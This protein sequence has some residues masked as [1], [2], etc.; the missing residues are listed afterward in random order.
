LYSESGLKQI[1]VPESCHLPW[2]G[3]SGEARNVLAKSA[4]IVILFIIFLSV[5]RKIVAQVM[6]KYFSV[7]IFNFDW[8]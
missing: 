3:Q 7:K 2:A 6:K 1:P 4:R 5:I 8:G